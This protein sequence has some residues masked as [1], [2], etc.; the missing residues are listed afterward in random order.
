[1]S[2]ADGQFK[3]TMSNE[4]LKKILPDFKFKSLKQGINLT[5][6]HLKQNLDQARL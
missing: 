4:L 2:K 3:K 6:S 5:I 1:L